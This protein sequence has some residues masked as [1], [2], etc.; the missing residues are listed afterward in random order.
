M[1]WSPLPAKTIRTVDI[2]WKAL[3]S[4]ADCAS[5]SEGRNFFRRA[6]YFQSG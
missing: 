2:L 5:P 1:V 6:R 3:G 4:T